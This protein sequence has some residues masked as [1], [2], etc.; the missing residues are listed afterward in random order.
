MRLNPKDMV[1]FVTRIPH[2]DRIS[3]DKSM[4]RNMISTE[5]MWIH[6]MIRMINGISSA[7]NSKMNGMNLIHYNQ[8][9][10]V[11]ILHWKTT[12]EN[13]KSENKDTNVPQ[14]KNSLADDPHDGCNSQSIVILRID[15]S[16]SRSEGI[17]IYVPTAHHPQR[18]GEG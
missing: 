7:L 18:E 17:H 9:N 10:A 6:R 3:F 14:Q 12:A 2:S 13:V 1:C 16:S 5:P 11:H 4:D 15:R 8:R